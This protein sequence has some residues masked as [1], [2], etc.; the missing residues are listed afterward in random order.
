MIAMHTTIRMGHTEITMAATKSI[1]P[2]TL[3]ALGA[4][5]LAVAL[6]EHAES[7][8]ILRKKLRMLLAGTKGP[9]KLAAE[10]GKRI[11][12]IGRSR[13]FVDWD[14]RKALVQEL[15]HIR[16]TIGTTLAAQSPGVA[17][18]R[19]WEFVGIADRVLERVGDGDRKSV[20]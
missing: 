2:E 10:L 9:G 19:L 7:D 14:K 1:T 5:A 20:V 11:Q 17:I 6:I 18:E 8:S 16:M 15:A 3:V 13:S 4:P 12:T